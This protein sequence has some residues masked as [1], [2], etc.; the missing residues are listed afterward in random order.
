[1]KSKSAINMTVQEL[2]DAGYRVDIM[3]GS[4]R[5][6][7]ED[8]QKTAPITDGKDEYANNSPISTYSK[9]KKDVSNLELVDVYRVLDLFGVT[10]HAI[11]HAVKKLLMAGQRTGEKSFEKDLQEARDTINRKLEMLSEDQKYM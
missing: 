4:N 1:M 10:D 2:L 3:A 11:G 9:Y 5:N 8:A 7:A 6:Y